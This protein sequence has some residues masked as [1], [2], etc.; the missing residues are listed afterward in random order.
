MEALRTGAFPFVGL[1][2]YDVRV[3]LHE[4]HGPVRLGDYEPRHDLPPVKRERR[5]L[6][7]GVI[8]EEVVPVLDRKVYETWTED[9]EKRGRWTWESG[10]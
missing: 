1:T 7:R 10:L 4:A 6:T 9:G 8:V 2:D 5:D 3:A